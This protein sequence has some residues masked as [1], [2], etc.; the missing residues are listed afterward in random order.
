LYGIIININIKGLQLIMVDIGI[1][2]KINLYVGLNDI[3]FQNNDVLE[4]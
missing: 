3:L 4:Y 2:D 1:F